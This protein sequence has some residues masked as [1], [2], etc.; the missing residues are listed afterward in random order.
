[1]NL[2]EQ[3]LRVLTKVSGSTS[4]ELDL[5]TILVAVGNDPLYSMYS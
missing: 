1:M 5:G 3:L 2:L 4:E